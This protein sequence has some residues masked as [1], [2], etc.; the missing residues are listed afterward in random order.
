MNKSCACMRTRDNALTP[1]TG[2]LCVPE[3]R[4][5]RDRLNMPSFQAQNNF[6][7]CLQAF[8]EQLHTNTKA[9]WPLLLSAAV[10]QIPC[11]NQAPQQLAYLR[12]FQ[13]R[14]RAGAHCR[15]ASS[16]MVWI[17]LPAWGMTWR[18][19]IAHCWTPLCAC[20]G[21]AFQTA[22]CTRQSMMC[23]VVIPSALAMS[24]AHFQA[25]ALRAQGTATSQASP[26]TYCG[27]PLDHSITSCTRAA[28]PGP[29]H[30]PG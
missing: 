9:Q 12:P 30:R 26:V 27:K 2:M 4:P 28:H 5:L 1:C 15:A 21:H 3:T 16:A 24:L 6:P 22:S 13:P 8:I 23:T 17:V 10:L 14:R 29:S 7:T 25:G 11:T 20:I 18:L 19:A